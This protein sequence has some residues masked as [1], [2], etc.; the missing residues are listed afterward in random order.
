MILKSSRSSYPSD[1]AGK[2]KKMLVHDQKFYERFTGVPHRVE[3]LFDYRSGRK[4][5]DIYVDTEFWAT[6]ESKG[7]AYDEIEDILKVYHLSP[8]KYW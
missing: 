7:E 2:E 1:R 3:V 6:A 5:Y 8:I 4:C